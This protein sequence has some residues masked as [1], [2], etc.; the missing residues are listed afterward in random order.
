MSNKQEKKM[1]L[2]KRK[3]CSEGQNYFHLSHRNNGVFERV[4]TS[5]VYD[6]VD[7]LILSWI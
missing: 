2:S 6:L 7:N 1:N 4:L 5:Y 3:S